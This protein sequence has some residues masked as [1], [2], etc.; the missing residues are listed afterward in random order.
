VHRYSADGH[1]RKAQRMVRKIIILILNFCVTNLSNFVLQKAS[2]GTNPHYFDVWQHAHH[3]NAY[4]VERLI[5]SS[6]YSYAIFITFL[7]NSIFCRNDI[8][9]SCRISTGQSYKTG[10]QS[11]STSM[12]HMLQAEVPRM[13]SK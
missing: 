4:A 7:L 1:V 3:D 11:P 9:R 12:L 10:G 8:R 6:F 2:T 5:S 13:D